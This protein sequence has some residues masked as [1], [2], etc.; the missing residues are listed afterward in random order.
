MNRQ[1]T[2]E[3]VVDHLMAQRLPAVAP[4]GNCY[5]RMA[6]GKRCAIGALIPD[7]LY[8]ERMELNGVANIVSAFPALQAVLGIESPQDVVF[9]SE[10]QELHDRFG[11]FSW[12]EYVC[13]D[14]LYCLNGFRD[15]HDLV[16]RED[17][18]VPARYRR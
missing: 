4:E 11:L 3:K 5:Y 15:R 14:F 16:W 1:K 6:N 7:E 10:L 12:E 13:K 18:K 17:W 8:D 2:F 9:L